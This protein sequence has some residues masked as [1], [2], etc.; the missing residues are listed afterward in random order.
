[1]AL[2]SGGLMGNSLLKVM[3]VI[4]CTI[5]AVMWEFY[6]QST[7]MAVIWL[8]VAIAF[9]GWFGYDVKNR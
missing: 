8:L 3:V 6:T 4:L 9:T 1:M 5:N 2:V 7:F